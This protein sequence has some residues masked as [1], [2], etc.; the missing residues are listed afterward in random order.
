VDQQTAKQSVLI[1]NW[2]NVAEAGR[3]LQNG[4]RVAPVSFAFGTN[5]F[6]VPP[7]SPVPTNVA[8]ICKWTWMCTVQNIHANCEGYQLIADT[9]AR[10]FGVA[11][12]PVEC[13][14]KS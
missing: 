1:T 4:F 13:T 11:P 9:F 14:T 12:K 2:L 5:D 7:N 8:N 6:S 10:T 3:Y